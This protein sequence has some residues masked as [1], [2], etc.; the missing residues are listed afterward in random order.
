[1]NR[2]G[3]KWCW[4]TTRCKVYAASAGVL[5]AL[6]EGHRGMALR[7]RVME[8]Y[9]LGLDMFEIAPFRCV[10]CGGRC[11]PNKGRD[12]SA[13]RLT[14]D[15]IVPRSSNREACPGRKNL[16]AICG[17]CNSSR[18]CK[19]LRR[20]LHDKHLLGEIPDPPERVL[21]RVTLVREAPISRR[22]ADEMVRYYYP[23]FHRVQN[24]RWARR[25]V[26]GDAVRSLPF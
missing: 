16:M 17:R 13:R 7:R 20:W 22:V 8:L 19:P 11:V 23:G 4:T 2:F 15:H 12:D 10:I 6:D 9:E 14:L 21:R 25:K 18:G 3:F 24:G 5:L 1:M 26:A